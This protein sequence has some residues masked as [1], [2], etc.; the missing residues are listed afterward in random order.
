MQSDGRQGHLFRE[1]LER[2]F[3]TGMS[4]FVLLGSCMGREG[5]FAFCGM[6]GTDA[7]LQFS[8]KTSPF[9][10]EL[11]HRK[12]NLCAG[13]IAQTKKRVPH[14]RTQESFASGTASVHAAEAESVIVPVKVIS[15]AAGTTEICT[16]V[17]E[18][19]RG[20]LH[21]LRS[22]NTAVIQVSRWIRPPVTS[23]PAIPPSAA[24]L[25][26]VAVTVRFSLHHRCGKSWWQGRLKGVV[27]RHL[28][29]SRQEGKQS[30]VDYAITDSVRCRSLYRCA[31]SFS[32]TAE[33][34]FSMQVREWS[35]AAGLL[36][37]T[38]A[39]VPVWG[40]IRPPL[41]SAR[42]SPP[43]ASSLPPAAA[44]VFFSLHCSYR[45]CF[46]AVWSGHLFV[47]RPE[48]KQ[49]LVDYA[50]TDS[51]PCRSPY[52]CAVS[53]SPTAE[54]CFSMQ[55]H[56]WSWSA[57][58]LIATRA[59][60]PV[61]GW[62]RPPLASARA[63]PPAA[64]SLPP[65]AAPVFFSLH[66]SYRG[67]FRAVWSGH[68]FVSRPE[69]KQSLVDY[70]ITDSVRCRSL[71]RCAVSFSPTAEGCLSMQVHEWSWSAGLL[72][73][74]R[75]IVPVWGWMRPP[76][77]S[78]RASP[79]AASS[80][81]PAAAPVFFSLHCSYRGCF[82]AVWSGHL[83]VSRP[84]GKQSLVDFAIADSVSYSCAARSS[85]SSPAAIG[86]DAK[87]VRD[88]RCM[89]GRLITNSVVIQASGWIR[90]PV[91]STP[92][93]PPSA[94]SS[95]RPVV[96]RMFHASM[97]ASHRPV[98]QEDFISTPF[99]LLGLLSQAGAVFHCCCVVLPYC[100][101]VRVGTASARSA[102]K[103][104]CDARC[105]AWRLI[106]K[107]AIIQAS[108]WIRPPVASTPAIPPSAASSLRPVAAPVCFSLHHRCG[109]SWW[110]GRLKGVVS[111]HLSVSRQEG[112]QSLVDYA[113]T[114][115]V[116]CRSLYRCAV[117]FSPTAEGCLSM[118]VHEWSWSA[119][120]LIATR[121]IVRVSACI[122]PPLASAHASP[123]AA[124]SLPPATAP[125]FFSLQCSC[126]GCFRAVRSGHLF[127]SRP[128]GKQSLVD[129]GIA[130]S[131]SYSCAAR[132]SQS[133][134]AAIGCDAKLVR[135]AR[136]MA[137][138]LITNFVV[139][140]ASG[141][142]RPPVTST[143]AIPPSAA[144]SLRPVAVRMCHASLCA[145]HRPV[146]QEDS[147]LLALLSQAG[148]V[149][150]FGCSVLPYGFIVWVSIASARSATK[151]VR[152][153]RCMAGR[154]ITNRAIIQAS[155]W[156]RPPVTSAHAIPP[157]AASSLRPVAV[158]MCHASLCASH[159]PV[160]QEDFISTSSRLLGLLSQAGAV[161]H[162]G[163]AV[164]P[165]CFVRV[166][167][168]SARSA[169]KHVRDARCM[170]GRLIKS[171]AILQA[172]GWIRPPVTSAHAIP[173]SAASSL[174][175]VAVRMC[176]ASLCASH[177]PVLQEDSRLL[178]LLSQA[179]A[180]SHFGCSV[181]PYGFIVWVSI[182]LTRSAAKHV[183]DARCM[184]NG[185]I[186]QAC[187]WIRP[188]VATARA[189]SP[190]AAASLRPVAA[191]VHH[192]SPC[193]SQRPV[194]HENFKS[195]PSRLLRFPSQ[196]GSVS[197][198]VCPVLLCCSVVRVRIA[199]AR[200]P[201]KH[202]RDARC[203]AERL[204][205]N[206]AI[207]Q[208]SGWIRP[209]VTSEHA[210]P[211]SAASSLRPVAVRT[212][213]ASP[214]AS[215]CLSCK[216]T[217]GSL[218]FSVRQV[219]FPTLVA[220]CCVVLPYCFVVRVR[221][222]LTRSA[223]KHVCDARCMANG[224]IIQACGWIRPPFASA[225][226]I[227]PSAASSLRPVAAPVCFLQCSYGGCFRAVR[228]GHLFVS[229]SA[230]GGRAKLVRDARCMAGRLITNR[231]IIRVSGWICPR[232]AHDQRK[233][234]ALEGSIGKR[235]VLVFSHHAH[236]SSS[237]QANHSARCI[238]FQDLVHGARMAFSKILRP[239]QA[240]PKRHAV[241]RSFGCGSRMWAPPSP[242]VGMPRPSSWPSAAFML[243]VQGAARVARSDFRDV[244]FQAA[245]EAN[246][247]E[248]HP[249]EE[250]LR[251]AQVPFVVMIRN[252]LP[253]L[254]AQALQGGQVLLDLVLV[255]HSHGGVIAHSMAQSL[256]CAGFL[257]RGIV[258]VDT[259]GLPRKASLRFDPQALERHRS[260]YHWHL[261]SPKVN[262]MA[263][264]VPR[265]MSRAA[266]C[267]P[268]SG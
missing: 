242:K 51:V 99:R 74:T 224:A 95:L 16:A 257:V 177:R 228:S 38:R 200:S 6:A 10:A 63:S 9:I 133:S 104:V 250:T 210:I 268:A 209:P 230:T 213:H 241:L 14:I 195:T 13:G 167:I 75:A 222:A 172:C 120:L 223:A 59:I 93:I 67:C 174:R 65:A 103:H 84:E 166:R 33:G 183:R 82:R 191:P 23:T 35:G 236:Q 189:I 267:V 44:P 34:C 220:S 54:G 190:S 68:L 146:L 157:S 246:Y 19:L 152:D 128:E 140:Q 141:W 94:A 234:R 121:A 137:G 254:P 178:A 265:R 109:K 217:P 240:A 251:S 102:A 214:C 21:M 237:K 56:E 119:G 185:A 39:I 231:A 27:S 57:G 125:V 55:V 261:S 151:H 201:A 92:A 36:I 206:G 182:A 64:S 165:Y 12:L 105:M 37:K 245:V 192:A 69:G 1:I 28:S 229:R 73:A 156:I 50:I 4:F 78:A 194:L 196:A 47:S 207:I 41:A 145:S 139:I 5:K 42:A 58:L 180:V 2:D 24:S 233:C 3:R 150:H 244:G 169:A 30:L 113:I 264:E 226:A 106:T 87:L 181:L 239:V 100:F 252:L 101:V 90:P 71:Y 11:V 198:F 262:M 122:R 238:R 171:G 142:I 205:T 77:A 107:R 81:P 8:V 232:S 66:C 31:V 243:G 184:A 193:A 227:P 148:A 135:D 147:R 161:S 76:L 176:H 216:K 96:V 153:A 149:S 158:R 70:A 186:I 53:F 7:E 79:P 126:I 173:P 86:C 111:R 91:T 48:G 110:Q 255:G 116:R 259:L 20:T 266:E 187:G 115:S 98:L 197:H 163:C 132:S 40:W 160:L 60:V 215:N 62:I 253:L 162:F 144:S 49:S 29:V 221:I 134:P 108:G 138:R 117:S 61:W 17:T 124:S 18:W 127:A 131:V 26:P 168:A 249:L 256:E 85:Q 247:V 202:V 129:L 235:L 83:F 179:G 188:P 258:A 212:H 170:A 15:I 204:I 208:A 25:R 118:Q 80:L 97:C 112:K 143:P 203:M 225:R 22:T 45:G 263:P 136:C 123:P 130:D 72:I 248:I 89:A 114:D 154:L 32:P 52:R 164:L 218:G 199:T 219:Q 43:A 88:A 175:P 159:R 260:P 46:R 155:G 211:A